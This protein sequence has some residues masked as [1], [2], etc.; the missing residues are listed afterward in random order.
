MHRNNREYDLLK[1]PSAFRELF[2]HKPLDLNCPIC[3]LPENFGKECRWHVAQ[4]EHKDEGSTK[5]LH[6][7]LDCYYCGT[8][9]NPYRRCIKHAFKFREIDVKQSKGERS[10]QASP[11]YTEFIQLSP[12]AY[13]SLP[14][15]QTI[16]RANVTDLLSSTRSRPIFESDSRTSATRSQ[17]GSSTDVLVPSP[18]T[19]SSSRSSREAEQ[20]SAP[21][22]VTSSFRSRRKNLYRNLAAYVTS[23]NQ[24]RATSDNCDTTSNAS[25]VD[26]L[27]RWIQGTFYCVICMEDVSNNLMPM[28]KLTPQCHH[29]EMACLQCIEQALDSQ[30]ETEFWDRLHCPIC[31]GLLSHKSLQQYASGATFAR[32]VLN[33][34]PVTVLA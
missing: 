8:G 13:E 22:S 25:E 33:Q 5:F 7:A 11:A 10:L 3:R 17:P 6:K 12:A 18:S 24:S 9:N 2:T 30:I 20:S 31:P 28:S 34:R 1:L 4:R 29:E 15:K 26:G 27:G 32:F 19:N 21:S 23:N 14:S 16:S